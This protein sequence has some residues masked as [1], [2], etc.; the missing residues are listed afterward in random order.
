MS[1]RC[2]AWTNLRLRN[3]VAGY[4]LCP[5]LPGVELVDRRDFPIPG[6]VVDSRSVGIGASPHQIRQVIIRRDVTPSGSIAV[7]PQEV[8]ER[9]QVPGVAVLGVPRAAQH[10]AGK[11]EAIEVDVVL[12][13]RRQQERR[14]LRDRCC[15]SP[16]GPVDRLQRG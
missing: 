8:Q 9:F 1:C 4:V 12:E 15:L 16:L 11:E 2:R 7:A 5:H 14:P 6:R 13:R 3:W 10:L